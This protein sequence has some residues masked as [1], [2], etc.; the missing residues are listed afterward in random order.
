MLKMGFL[1]LIVFLW[2][3]ARTLLLAW[4]T[5]NSTNDASTRSF[6]SAVFSTLIGLLALGIGN[7]SLINGRFALV[8]A[9]IFGCVAVISR[10][11]KTMEGS[12]LT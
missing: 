6:C 7:A 8:Y 11:S 2:M 10:E 1:G 4:R 3:Y 12:D 9:V 5:Y